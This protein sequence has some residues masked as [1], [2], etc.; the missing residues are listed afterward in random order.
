M[1]HTFTTRF[2]SIFSPGLDWLL[3]I[4]FL[5]VFN[6]QLL[7]AQCNNCQVTITAP[8]AGLTTVGS[9]LNVCIT[10]SGTFSG[11]INLSGNNSICVSPGVMVSAASITPNGNNNS[12]I[13]Y[14]TWNNTL[15][16][17]GNNLRSVENYGTMT[18]GGLTVDGN[19]TFTNYRTLT[20]NGGMILQGNNAIFINTVTGRATVNGN[21]RVNGGNF[22]NAGSTAVTKANSTNEG[23]FTQ[24]GNQANSSVTGPLLIDGN[25]TIDEGILDLIKAGVQVGG[26]YVQQGSGNTRVSGGD[27]PATCGS[28]TVN[29]TS[30]LNGGVFGFKGFL[31]MCDTGSAPG[32]FGFDVRNGGTIS[33]DNNGNGTLGCSCN[34]PLPV[35][36]I[37]FTFQQKGNQVTLHWATSS[38]TDND[39]FAIEKSR[40]G[41]EF[42]EISRIKGAGNST[43]KLTYQ[44]T[45][46]MLYGGVSYYRLK[47]V[48]FDGTIEYSKIVSVHSDGAEALK[49]YPNPLSQQELVVEMYDALSGDMRITVYDALGK[50]RLDKIVAAQPEL[51]VNLGLLSREPGV[52][53][54]AIRKN[55]RIE[56]QR[57]IIQ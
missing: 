57:L 23:N 56:R 33:N 16:S 5:F 47:Q 17:L 52:Y 24:Q 18:T 49:I 2:Y 41:K 11:T 21:I 7:Q 30:T 51:K 45:D 35:S 10:G 4:C 13:N 26:N 22:N 55:N 34:Q 25:F 42:R 20:I 12:I 44:Y 15:P 39:Y 28:F 3:A 43:Q 8:G 38:E 53:I 9:G 54:V 31:G 19:A 1:M 29:G 48:D 6:N 40:D 50:V 36:L 46:D 14:G 27:T 37:Y 32:N